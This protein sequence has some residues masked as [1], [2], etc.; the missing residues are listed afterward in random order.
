M[1]IPDEKEPPCVVELQLAV[2][3]LQEQVDSLQANASKNECEE[4][5]AK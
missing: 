5:M 3:R 2:R 4:P 1:I